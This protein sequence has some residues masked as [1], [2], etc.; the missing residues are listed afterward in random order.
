MQTDSPAYL[1][2][3]R[4]FT[5]II[6]TSHNKISKVLFIYLRLGGC[7]TSKYMIIYSRAKTSMGLQCGTTMQFLLS[8][9]L[10]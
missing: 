4:V 9:E 10:N 3:A 7:H 1:L 8:L 2:C 6:I 5:E